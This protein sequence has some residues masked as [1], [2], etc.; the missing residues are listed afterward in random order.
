MFEIA[1]RLLQCL[2]TGHRVAVATA[3]AI[4]GSAPRTVGTSMGVA[5]DGT[6][7]GS[8]SGGCVEGA[9]YEICQR[10]LE[11]GMPEL[12][13]FG[14]D[15][16]IAF[17]VGLSCG[18]RIE[19]LVQVIDPAH[20]GCRPIADQL[21]RA[22]SGQP[23]ELSWSL[24]A[25]AERSHPGAGS[26]SPV[27]PS[28]HPL[29]FLLPASHRPAGC[30]VPHNERVF[31][32]RFSSPARLI[33]V[34]AVEFAVALCAAGSA[35]GYLVTVV[36]ARPVFTTSARFPAADEVVVEWPPQYLARTAVDARTAICLVSHDDRFDVDVIERALMLPV[37]YVGAMGSRATHEL[38]VRQLRE[39]GVRDLARLHSPIGLDLGASTPAET[40]ISILAEVLASK[41]GASAR[42][43]TVLEGAIHRPDEER[44]G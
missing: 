31:T 9:L 4:T 18:G 6:V 7:I 33:I 35:L 11:T 44:S 36:D 38:R 12:A 30:S 17:S 10:V 22:A 42:P 20:A 13:T 14:F 27:A 39:R 25:A 34:G 8:I 16:E 3:V 40:A 2:D 28:W 24:G 41:T 15:D 26:G 1:D 21:R 5:D 43:L 32:E 29:G 19:T 37:A 23:A